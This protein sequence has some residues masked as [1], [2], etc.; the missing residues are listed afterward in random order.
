MDL[1]LE[2]RLLNDLNA[3]QQEAVTAELGSLLILAGAGSGKTTVLTRR[4]AYLLHRF[5]AY[6][7]HVLSVTFTNKA[8]REMK[9]RDAH[10]LNNNIQGM[11][12]GTFHSLSHKLLRLHAQSAGLNEHFT[13]LDSEDQHQLIKKLLKQRELNEERW[14]A[15]KIQ[16]HI[17]KLKD[18][19]I[20]TNNLPAPKEYSDQIYQSIYGAYEQLCFKDSLVDFAELLLRCYELLKNNPAVLALYQSRFKHIL[21][22]EFQDT[23]AIQYHWLQLLAQ[24]ADS[25][26]AVGDDDQ[27]IYGWR[28][29]RVE[30]IQRFIN[31]F[32][33]TKVIR[34]E[35]NYRSTKI[36][37]NAANQVIENNQD[38]LGKTLWS[39]GEEGE[40]IGVY[41]GYNEDDEA[42]FV[43]RT[44]RSYLHQQPNMGLSYE[45]RDIGVLY[46]SNAQSR[47]LEDA[48]IRAGIPYVV[49]GG[50]RFFERAEIKDALSYLKL[51]VNPDD[52]AAF[53]RVINVP[54]RGLGDKTVEKLLQ[55]AQEQNLSLW[56]SSELALQMGQFSGRMKAALERFQALILSLQEVAAELD[57]SALIEAV[58]N[59]TGLLE[60]YQN[61]KTER[62][63]GKT[64]NLKELVSA[65]SDF[66]VED[67]EAQPLLE[68]LS[69]TSLESGEKQ[70]KDNNAVTLMTLHASKGLEFPVVFMTGL[71]EN[72]FPH[73]LSKDKPESLQEE[74]RLCYVGITRAMKKLFLC[75]ANV[76]RVFGREELRQPSR[77]LSE[78]PEAVLEDLG[79]R[80]K[81]ARFLSASSPHK[82][83]ASSSMKSKHL[84]KKISHA[85]FGMGEVIDQEGEGDKVKIH[86]D[87]KHFGSKWLLLSVANI[88]FV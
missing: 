19:G 21:I 76:R 57:L 29:A 64:D 58:L 70:S 71:E 2:S 23:N 85:K 38:R 9:Q 81:V 84:G 17:N 51:I 31:E 73:Q 28:G 6:P 34:L 56:G 3:A 26:M 83:N 62:S 49:Y 66:D 67:E 79:P 5:G 27:S 82:I 1:Q 22:D 50:F 86:V 61:Q 20:R 44:I 37:L 54:H 24:R 41:N 46:R 10:L 45:P 32:P 35:Q 15:R 60:F 8:A 36:I 16:G 80:L 59:Q 55:I 87:F 69:Y 25:V 78:L 65:A 39:A 33:G 43:A 88:E 74:R 63:E 42:I 7:S 11:W 18:S 47:V 52:N 68:F 13:I 75:W 77:F 30:N 4:K 48:F 40:K 53:E 14:D 12:T 72:L